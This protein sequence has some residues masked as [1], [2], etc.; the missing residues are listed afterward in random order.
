M[1]LP[2]GRRLFLAWEPATGGAANANVFQQLET[3]PRQPRQCL[4]DRYSFVAASVGRFKSFESFVNFR[5]LYL[6]TLLS[7][8]PYDLNSRNCYYYLCHTL[9]RR[10]TDER[11]DVRSAGVA[12][13]K[14]ARRG[15]TERALT[16]AA[17]PSPC[18]PYR[19]VLA[20]RPSLKARPLVS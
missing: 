20:M 3:P 7:L 4:A 15:N 10:P 9:Y 14:T 5:F 13:W 18:D 17:G 6:I 12:D 1:R 19:H 8:W 16:A 11:G 2:A